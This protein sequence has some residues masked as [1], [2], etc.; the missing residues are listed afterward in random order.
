MT[1]GSVFRLEDKR[2]AVGQRG[3]LWISRKDFLHHYFERVGKN[4]GYQCRIYTCDVEIRKRRKET[5]K[6][7]ATM[8]SPPLVAHT[9]T[10]LLDFEVIVK[11]N[12]LHIG[13]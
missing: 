1:F 12:Q 11:L 13:K 3:E 9:R 7:E 8:Q 6:I 5:G 4:I 10:T 2:R